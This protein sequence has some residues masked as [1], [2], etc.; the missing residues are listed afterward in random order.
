M[1]CGYLVE[2]LLSEPPLAGSEYYNRDKPAFAEYDPTCTQR[3]IITLTRQCPIDGPPITPQSS[4]GEPENSTFGGRGPASN[5]ACKRFDDAVNDLHEIFQRL[6]DFG[7]RK[8]AT[9]GKNVVNVVA[10]KGDRVL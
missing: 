10:G 3:G 1:L 2:S 7:S 5:E 9:L 6:D 4:V 8:Q